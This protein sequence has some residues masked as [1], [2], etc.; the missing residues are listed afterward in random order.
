MVAGSDVSVELVILSPG[1]NVAP[2]NE[3]CPRE[4]VDCLMVFS[5]GTRTGPLDRGGRGGARGVARVE[6]LVVAEEREA[7]GG[8]ERV[9]AE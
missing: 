9:A 4:V 5:L 6:G 8:G 7:S 1:R 2:R 3:L